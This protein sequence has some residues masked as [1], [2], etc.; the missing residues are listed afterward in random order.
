M[1][2]EW[3]TVST[4]VYRG[5]ATS[6]AGIGVGVVPTP[7]N[8]PTRDFPSATGYLPESFNGGLFG[9]TVTVRIDTGTGVAPVGTVVSVST[10]IGWRVV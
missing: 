4:L 6:V 9:F 2:A 1:D 10:R 3:V 5:D 7:L 8:F